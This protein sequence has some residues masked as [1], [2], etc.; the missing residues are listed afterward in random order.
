MKVSN[1]RNKYRYDINIYNPRPID[2]NDLKKVNWRTS[3]KLSTACVKCGSTYKLQNHHIRPLRNT[4]YVGF[5]KTIASLN[6]KQITICEKCH[7]SIHKGEYNDTSLKDL[8]DVQLAIPENFLK[9]PSTPT[10]KEK[11]KRKPNILIDENK[12]TYLNPELRDFLIKKNT[13]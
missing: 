5:D 13:Q 10:P 4:K 2:F 1:L 6:R 12:K 11:S 9:Y 7:I 3:F 8:Y